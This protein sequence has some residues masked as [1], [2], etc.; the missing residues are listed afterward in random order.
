[1]PQRPASPDDR[2]ARHR[3]TARALR[4]RV[5][6]PR[7][8][9]GDGIDVDE[10]VLRDPARLAAVD[11][12]LRTLPGQ[13][14]ALD[15]IAALAA[16]LLDAP[17]AAVTLVGQDEE[18]LVGAYGLP[19]PLSGRKRAPLAYSVCKYVV[20]SD[21]AVLATD[22][23]DARD[24]SLCTHLLTTELGIRA[25][26]GV[27]VRDPEDRP[28]GSLTVL[29]HRPR[30]WTGEQVS[31]LLAMAETV[32]APAAV[33]PRAPVPAGTGA[34]LDA[35]LECLPAGVMACDENGRVVLANRVSREFR[36][37]PVEGP[38]PDDF[39]SRTHAVVCG[40]ENEPI[41]WE[42]TP[43]MRAFRGEYVF[44]EDVL[45]KLP[46]HRTRILSSS[47]RPVLGTDARPAAAWVSAWPA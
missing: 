33:Q 28:L 44:E 15:A 47:A 8:E 31:T 25:F 13:T 35:L 18:H 24:G 41:P 23:T 19:E 37:L 17:I 26:A 38:I 42:R 32:L 36:G 20:S 6:L 4:R 22:M 2:E 39:P 12:A 7:P 46:G 45:A 9:S 30:F 27:P 34:L 5:P 10:S 29:D 1:M 40:P 21:H 11:R 43:L 14:L 3:R 16:R